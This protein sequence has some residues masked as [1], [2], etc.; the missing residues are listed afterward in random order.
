[1]KKNSIP[2]RVD[3][4]F[5][6]WCKDMIKQNPS[7]NQRKLTRNLAKMKYVIGDGFLTNEIEVFNKKRKNNKR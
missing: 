2:M 5:Y 3:K 4:E 1:M 6:D 7:L